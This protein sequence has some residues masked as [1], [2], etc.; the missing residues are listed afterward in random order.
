MCWKG[1]DCDLGFLALVAHT[2]I[3][4]PYSLVRFGLVWF[5][6]DCKWG[7]KLDMACCSCRSS[8]R[9]IYEIHY[10]GL[11]FSRS[12]AASRYPSSRSFSSR[13]SA[14]DADAGLAVEMPILFPS[15]SSPCSAT[16]ARCYISHHFADIAR[17][18]LSYCVLR[19]WSVCG[20][21][22]SLW[23]RTRL[24]RT[25]HSGG[26]HLCHEAFFV[27]GAGCQNLLPR[28]VEYS[29]WRYDA[30]GKEGVYG[31]VL[32]IR[33]PFRRRCVRWRRCQC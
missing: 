28:C 30:Q 29:G 25:A 9:A 8:G 17:S 1:G 11:I 3:F 31:V 27:G 14:F 18:L 7:E 23:R 16:H 21:R 5:G 6:L 24:T 15:F 19:T 32:G 10:G 12:K 4:L 33:I 22:D 2:S 13:L 20:L 26:L